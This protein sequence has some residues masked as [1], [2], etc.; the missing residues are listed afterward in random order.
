MSLVRV[1]TPQSASE[2]MV[3]VAMLEAY[4]I[5]TLDHNGHLASILPGVQISAYNT[6]SIMVPEEHRQLAETLLADFRAH[7]APDAPPKAST[8]SLRNI[9]EFLLM[10][11]FIPRN[12]NAD[13]TALAKFVDFHAVPETA[14]FDHQKLSFAVMLAHHSE[15][16]VL[17][18]N[19][20][21]RVWELPGG[22][23]DP[24]ESPRDTAPRELREEAG[25]VARNTTWLGVVEVDDARR[26]FGGV[27]R[28]DVDDIPPK[29]P[30]DEIGG[31]ACWLPDRAPPGLGATD[32]ALLERFGRER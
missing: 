21:R 7:D 9:A 27:F 16:V 11:W 3:V 26:H 18:F 28:C 19:R 6:A 25:C 5:P 32:E 15:G 31:V 12:A 23:V 22:L 30:D 13:E 8:F 2:R 29:T 17:V 14:A 24:G 10:G 4:G 1:F 20:Y